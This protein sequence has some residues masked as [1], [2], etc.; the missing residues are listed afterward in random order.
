MLIHH[1]CVLLPEEHTFF[2]CRIPAAYHSSLVRVD[3]RIV[4]TA[5]LIAFE[6][7][8]RIVL[9]LCLV[10]LLSFTM[11][12]SPALQATE[13]RVSFRKGRDNI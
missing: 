2:Y 12:P 10:T 5:V 1:R 7:I 4:K 9:F 8:H 13:R 3:A 11:Q 6:L